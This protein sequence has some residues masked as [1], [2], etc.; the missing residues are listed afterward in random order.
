[1]AQKI[2]IILI[3]VLTAS[4]L[5]AD[6]P[7]RNV[8][9]VDGPYLAPDTI[10]A[11]PGHPI[12]P[13]A[14]EN[15]TDSLS[16]YI[17][18]RMSVHQIGFVLPENSKF[19]SG[20]IKKR[21]IVLTFPPE[22]DLST[23]NSVTYLDKD[24][25]GYLPNI[26][27]IL[28]YSES[29]VI[30][31]T[32]YKNDPHRPYQVYFDIDAIAN[33]TRSGDF[34]IVVQVDNFF[35]QTVAGPN[36][37]NFFTIIPDEPAQ[38]AISPTGDFSIVA[39]E[40]ITFE[41]FIADQF[42]NF[43][44]SETA[45]WSLDASMN[46]VGRLFGP[47]FQA[48]TVGTG[49]VVAAAGDLT[50]Y[51][52]NI[53]VLP[54]ETAQLIAEHETE[55]VNTGAPLNNDITITLAD[56]FGNR[57]FD[58]IGK[59]W[60]ESDDSQAEVEYD[61][62]NPYEYTAQD[63]G[64]RVFSGDGFIF[65]TAGQRVLLVNEE[66]GLSAS[67]D[68]IFVISEVGDLVDFDV[69]YEQSIRAGEPLLI[70]I[71]NAVDSSGS[72]FTGVIN[73]SG[74]NIAPDGSEPLLN[75]IYV[76]NGSGSMDIRL[77]AAGINNLVLSHGDI[78]RAIEI[79]VLPSQTSRMDL[80]IDETQFIGHQI[81]GALVI[82]VFDR[83][84]NPKI[85]YDQVG[86]EIVFESET[87][88]F[89]P[90]AI[91]PSDFVNGIAVITDLTFNGQ[92]GLTVLTA[93][94]VVDGE[95]L[96]E[97]T[98]F[99]ANGITAKPNDDAPIASIIP[100]KWNARLRAFSNNFGNMTPIYIEYRAGIVDETNLRIINSPNHVCLPEPGD[101]NK[102]HV[103][104]FIFAN[105][106]PGFYEYVLITEA[107]YQIDDMIIVVQ[108]VFSHNFEIVPFTPLEIIS[109]NL[110]DTAFPYDYELPGEIV[111]KNDNV[112]EQAWN[113]G[114]SLGI[115]S[116]PKPY[117]LS[118]IVFREFNWD[119]EINL[120]LLLPFRHNFEYG[121]Y[122]YVMSYSFIIRYTDQ[123]IVEY[124]GTFDLN[125]TLSILPR[126]K[127]LV[128]ENA[129][130][131]NSAVAG[132][133]VPF[134]IPLK[135]IGSSTINLNGAESQLI[136]TDGS[137]SSSARLLQDE[138]IMNP[139]VT[140]ISSAPLT[141]PEEWIGKTLTAK[142]LLNGIE[143][144]VIPVNEIQ[145]FAFPVTVFS[146]QYLS[147]GH[148]SVQA[149]NTPYVN[150]GQEF[151]IIGYVINNSTDDFEEPLTIGLFSDG[152]SIAFEPVDISSVPAKDSVKVLFGIMGASNPNPAE[153]F[154]MVPLS[155]QDVLQPRP[156]NNIVVVIQTPADLTFDAEFVERPGSV[157][158]LDFAEEFSIMAEY[159]NNGQA[160]IEGGSLILD[161]FGP[162]DFGVSFPIELPLG[163]ELIW[164]LVSPASEINSEF[165]INWG[166]LPID[167]NTGEAVKDLSQPVVLPFL[168]KASMTKLVIQ[169]D[170]FDT[171][172]LVRD[173][174]A[175]LFKLSI[176]NVSNDIRN[177]VQI[178][179][180]T[181]TVTD[182][183][184][185]QIDGDYLVT[186]SGSAFY[187]DDQ[188]ITSLDLVDG[189]LAY[190][191][192]G[193][194]IAPGEKEIIELRFTPK[195]DAFFDFFNMR[196]ESADISAEFASGPRTGEKVTVTG[197]L[198]R[199]FEINLPQ[200]I[201]A[202]E[203]G[204][205]FKN[206]PN[207]FN[208]NFEE[209][210]FIYNLPTDSDVDIY[211]Y[212]VTGERVRHLHFDAGS[213]AGQSDQLARAYWD[214]RNGEGDVVLNGVYIAYIEVAEGNLTSKVKIAVVK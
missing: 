66:S 175:I 192:T 194:V 102:C 190:S 201:I 25:T 6:S 127:I 140:I 160:A 62:S 212:S 206:Y 75:S 207:P 184:G 91:Q 164:N 157:A 1:M 85:D 101:L 113:F 209:T 106:A 125:K 107:H 7:N 128:N 114:I 44:S 205:S 178:N 40:T 23:V 45:L 65:K 208:P 96:I 52:G 36:F 119:P 137:I 168:I 154:Y 34:R 176:E 60:F 73:T 186:E 162:G 163:D 150:T 16:D 193:S 29:V 58:F 211:I 67:I 134:T 43:I 39:G 11:S 111:I 82:K 27:G 118:H 112:F 81:F 145:S 131:P 19:P 47:V 99:Y 173:A 147:I 56:A 123:S 38:L 3:F 68:N 181:I 80:S 172:P 183:D 21:K 90:G 55:T 124:F 64:R 171:K 94:M 121:T 180:I 41:A 203:F 139:G 156:D 35:G 143:A 169:P 18:G 199:A 79:N 78:E 28:V 200:A 13:I 116:E 195:V 159:R 89:T 153:R 188:P 142:L 20:L 198:D 95:P 77:F 161:Y 146:T 204:E 170:E 84:E 51:S 191:F 49:R 17:A 214:G 72:P 210:E 93:K 15:I 92:P 187:L 129:I 189:K 105:I 151:G 48:T 103:T 108:T 88:E 213:T 138:Y 130:T 120:D 8:E 115:S 133:A 126:A 42:G 22:F 158:I 174:T 177:S 185:K 152:E 83:Y 166:E 46:Q 202:S 14:I 63:E 71:F 87:G 165:L 167:K 122:T 10:Q 4:V 24:S 149:P 70:S 57:K 196:L 144:D 69:S 110:P 59:V 197:I 100:E 155:G 37:S 98:E 76:H 97:N 135:L 50:A 104:D 5:A 54:G 109:A 74:G 141:I 33:P 117:N 31:I 2:L 30:E 53:T 61:A 26:T 132:S 32:E 136:V 9:F 182:R 86:S 12:N 179:T 148:L